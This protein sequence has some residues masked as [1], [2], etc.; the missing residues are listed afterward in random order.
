MHVQ[1][2]L[3]RQVKNMTILK[4]TSKREEM[5]GWLKQHFSEDVTED[6]MRAVDRNSMS[7]YGKYMVRRVGCHY[8]LLMLPE[9]KEGAVC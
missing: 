8:L 6:M 1:T 4:T 7:A 2:N 9:L 5:L 3:K